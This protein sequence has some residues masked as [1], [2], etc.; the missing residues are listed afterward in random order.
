MMKSITHLGGSIAG[1]ILLLSACSSF[2][3]ERFYC[4]DKLTAV[5]LG[6][7]VQLTATET[8]QRVDVRLNG[9]SAECYLENE[10]TVFE[11]SAGLK[12]TRDLAE[13]SDTT[14]VEVPFLVSVVDDDEQIVGHQ[15]FG[16][17]MAFRKDNGSLYPVAEFDV[18]APT[19][20]RIILSLT[21]QNLELD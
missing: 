7:R 3:P 14:Q 6:S 12:L 11:V 8:A 17:K 18:E 10:V 16:Y 4:N 1:F 21:T 15:S 13:A 2:E 9:V 5:E 20:G 19:D